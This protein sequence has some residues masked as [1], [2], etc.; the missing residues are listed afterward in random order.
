MKHI[1]CF[2]FYLATSMEFS[3]Q[4]WLG[5]AGVVS[6]VLATFAGFGLLVAAGAEFTNFNYGAIFIM[7]GIGQFSQFA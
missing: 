4:P 2:N 6:T 3:I 5:L 7:V 1:F